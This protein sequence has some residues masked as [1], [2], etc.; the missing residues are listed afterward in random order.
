[1]A[2]WL[3]TNGTAGVASCPDSAGLSIVGDI[4]LRILCKVPDWSPAVAYMF[5]CKR[6]SSDSATGEWQWSNDADTGG[7]GVR[8]VRWRWF[9]S[10]GTNVTNVS[11][12]FGGA[13]A[14][15]EWLAHRFF[16][17]VDDGAGNRV[18]TW[19]Y[20]IASGPTEDIATSSGWTNAGT[21]VTTA[22]T[23][24]IR[25]TAANLV[26]IGSQ[27][28]GTTSLM[29]SGSAVAKA[30]ILNGIA[31]TTVGSPDFT[32]LT[33]GQTSYTD[34]QGNVWTFSSGVTVATE[35]QFARPTSDAH[36]G[37]WLTDTGAA[38]NLF[39]TIDET[40]ASD[41]DYIRSPTDPSN[42][43]VVVKI[44]AIT[45]PA[46]STGHIFRYRYLKSGTATID[47]VAQLR[48]GYVSEG[49]PG[50]LIASASHTNISASA[51]TAALTLTGG[52]ADAI[53]NYGDLYFRFVA[54]KTA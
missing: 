26:E 4:D 43:P 13:A 34:A 42:A 10:V 40:T 46:S 19:Q 14:D 33:A 23:T 36:A 47:L 53:T 3:E 48:Q 18:L 41:A 11:G 29:A 1:M 37:S 51:T 31:G 5:M 27:N 44:G 52:E 24:N 16:F 25:G 38:T 2:T 8:F 49:S 22:G 28:S 50:T 45:D 21:P 12:T 54:N 32:A 30:L 7:T 9:D 35:A 17:D 39:A 6:H 20:K 15:G